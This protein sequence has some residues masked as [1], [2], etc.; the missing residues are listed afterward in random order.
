MLSSLV[1]PGLNGKYVL[2]RKRSQRQADQDRLGS[3]V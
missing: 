2:A 1:T 3:V